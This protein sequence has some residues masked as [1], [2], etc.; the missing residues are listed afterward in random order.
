[1]PLQADTLEKLI[2]DAF[3]DAKITITDLAGDND[4]W[5]VVIESSAFAGKS[6]IAQH[7][8]VY[9]SLQG[10]MGGELHALQLKTKVL[11]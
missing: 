7:K 3:S 2:K 9:D 10:K 6:R 8:M 4:H 1:M 5:S 11:K